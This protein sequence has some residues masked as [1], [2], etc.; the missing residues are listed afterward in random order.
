MI[1][2]DSERELTSFINKGEALEPTKENLENKISKLFLDSEKNSINLSSIFGDLAENSSLKVPTEAKDPTSGELVKEAGVSVGFKADPVKSNRIKSIAKLG[3]VG[4]QEDL[5]LLRQ[6]LALINEEIILQLQSC[7]VDIVV[8]R[9]NVTSGMDSLSGRKA[10]GGTPLDGAEG[11]MLADNGKARILV[12]SHMRDGKLVLD[13]RAL[14]HEI[15]HALS[16]ARGLDSAL[17]KRKPLVKSFE[18]LINRMHN[19]IPVENRGDIN[20][21]VEVFRLEHKD[22][23]NTYF[24]DFNEFLAESFAWFALRPDELKAKFPETY[25][26]YVE[27]YGSEAIVDTKAHIELDAKM[28]NSTLYVAEPDSSKVLAD[29]EA[30]NQALISSNSL[31]ESHA[32]LLDGVP[33]ANRAIGFEFAREL[34]INRSGMPSY[35]YGQG[36]IEITDQTQDLA[37]TLDE[38]CGSPGAILYIPDPSSIDIK[39][40]FVQLFRDFHDKNPG[41]CHLVI[42]GE[43]SAQQELLQALPTLASSKLETSLPTRENYVEMIIRLAANDG[44]VFSEEAK[45]NLD[46]LILRGGKLEEAAKI[47]EEIKNSQYQRIL[48]DSTGLAEEPRSVKWIITKDLSA[49]EQSKNSDPLENLMSLIGLDNVKERVVQILGS[50]Q[51]NKI[52]ESLGVSAVKS[53]RVTMVWPGNP[54]TGKTTVAKLVAKIFHTRGA[55]K[56]PEILEIGATDLLEKGASG[57]LTE[58]KKGRGGVIF[59]DEFHQLDPKN[60]TKGK[61][62]IDLLTPILTSEEWEDTVF[63]FAGYPKAISDMMESDEGLAGRLEEV[64]FEDYT[65]EE[66]KEIAKLMLSKRGLLFD[67][68]VFEEFCKSVERKQRSTRYPGNA[69]DVEKALDKVVG[70]QSS[71]ISRQAVRGEESIDAEDLQR[72]VSEDIIESAKETPKDVLK[73]LEEKIVGNDEIKAL[74]RSI[75]SI[76]A[77]NKSLGWDLLTDVPTGII[78]D[79]PAGTGKS[80]MAKYIGRFYH[81]LQILADDKVVSVTGGM[82]VGGFLGNSSALAADEKCDD[83]WGG[84]LFIDEVSSMIAGRELSRQS[85]KQLLTRMQDDKEKYLVVVADYP[86]NV[87]KFLAFDSGVQGRFKVRVSTEKLSPDNAIKL[88]LTLAGKREWKID[89]K[90]IESIS[91]DIKRL[92]DLPQFGSGRDIERLVEVIS[93]FQCGE[94]DALTKEEEIEN[95]DWTKI[96]P[97]MLKSALEKVIKDVKKRPSTEA[98]SGV[99]SSDDAL[100]Q[101]GRQTRSIDQVAEPKVNEGFRDAQKIVNQRYSDLAND[102]PEQFLALLED[103]NSEYY[104]DLGTELGVEPKE[105]HAQAVAVKEAI[106]KEIEEEKAANKVVMFDY[107]CPF[108]GGTNSMG[109]GYFSQSEAVNPDNYQFS[110]GWLAQHS[111]K[112]PYEVDAEDA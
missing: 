72:I 9:A 82:M 36:F 53:G 85:V 31:R 84:T 48:G 98:T 46:D 32:F 74:L 20:K 3:K 28:Y 27:L 80:T 5:N 97:A 70:R 7:K 103:S 41:L 44:F 30:R 61:P 63:I 110:M 47:W 59:I 81:A 60:N 8:S 13:T 75:R 26:L 51:V 54:G 101:I 79:G 21:V 2:N 106:A 69:R 90:L 42:G 12:R 45:E 65:P 34:I 111:L 104:K 92:T 18:D 16:L 88:L 93:N 29:I 17:L 89:K 23:R 55:I 56:N 73:E 14:L 11:L 102:F 24:H 109:C 96:T 68:K 6:G 99:V 87:D 37:E 83:A 77:R 112:P 33:E 91:K 94:H 95:F 38:V 78:I 50:L 43:K 108:C 22:F 52:R 40:E 4:D 39:G 71:R 1:D 64:K 76:V 67:G 19:A 49:V 100:Y 57:A 62:I 66:L 107:E 86:H 58:F 35:E 105:A 15:G 10:G 25:K